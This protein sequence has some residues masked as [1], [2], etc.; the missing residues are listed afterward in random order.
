MYKVK[1]SQEE[2]ERF[3]GIS[4]EGAIAVFVYSKNVFAD[5]EIKHYDDDG[6]LRA[7]AF[8]GEIYVPVSFFERFLGKC[9]GDVGI[10]PRVSDGIEYMPAVRGAVA[11]GYSADVF[12]EGRLCVIGTEDQLSVMRWSENMPEAAA[13]TLFGEYDTS[14]LTSDDY[15]TA[16]ARWA[17]MLVGDAE[18]N[19][20]SDPVIKEKVEKVEKL[21]EDLWQKMNKAEDRIAL[22]GEKP[23]E[24]SATMGYWYTYLSNM[25]KAWGT[26]GTRLYHNEELAADI[27]DGL[28]WM[29]EHYYGEDV[30]NG[31]GWRSPKQFNW[32]DWFIPVPQAITEI[33]FIMEDHF[34][35]E[36]R[37]KYL[38]CFEW[39]TTHTYE[40]DI[41]THAAGRVGVYTMC[42]LATE[43]PDM[44]KRANVDFDWLLELV[45]DQE[46][47][48]VDFS[49]W[50]HGMAYNNAYGVMNLERGLRLAHF[51]AGTPLEFTSPRIYTYFDLVKY[52]F[53]P[54]M[55]N[56]R[57]MHFMSGRQTYLPENTRCVGI[58][59]QMLRIYGMFGKAEDEY[60]RKM[61]LHHTKNNPELVEKMKTAATIHACRQI[62]EL[63]KQ[64]DEDVPY[65]Y[66][67]SYYTADRAVQQRNN[68]AFAIT[69]SS[70]REPAFEATN[71]VN[72]NGWHLGDGMTHIYTDYD[73]NAYSPDNFYLKNDE[74][75]Y[76]LSGTTE[77]A[78]ERV[79]VCVA[80][81]YRAK[82]DFA[83]SVSVD[84][85]Y[86]VAAMEFMSLN[87]PDGPVWENDCG[88]S[89]PI[90]VND[91]T[92]KKSY[93]CFDK[94]MVCLG[95]GIRSTMDSPVSTTVEHVRI[96]SPD[97][98]E[99]YLGGEL[100]P[101]TDFEKRATGADFVNMK[102]HAGFVIFDGEGYVHRYSNEKTGLSYF[103]VGIDHGKNPS[104]ASYA[105]AVLPYADNGTLANYKSCGGV[106]IIK[107]T[108]ECQAVKKASVG[109]SAYVFY[110]AGECDGIKVDAP[111]IVTVKKNDDG[112]TTL[113]ITDPTQ[114]SLKVG[115][116]LSGVDEI[117]SS[118]S[119]IDASVTDGCLTIT[120]NT[121]NARGRRFEITVK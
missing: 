19:D 75:A 114:K 102:G 4:R 26:Y 99:Q 56:G 6:K 121:E 10:P 120:V 38:R 60:L 35:L 111:A 97:F 24:E 113:Q 117:V 108:A 34:T 68:Y 104:D 80:N 49:Q 17:Y 77:D 54:V 98:D 82:N 78:R 87:N 100:L 70:E 67:H 107:N 52:M 11:L 63:L 40:K 27:L 76:R 86:I 94:E 41:R 39:I 20:L 51:L 32:W 15:K 14:K 92:A 53:E 12:Y 28:E 65:E 101:K 66:A 7:V 43:N 109:L 8:D 95:A 88:H 3:L 45:D 50:T 30:I 118:S 116:T 21:G 79:A 44:L 83:G 73:P 31:V 105:Y 57:A 110:E 9:A 25:A 29:Y 119:K 22:F 2:K 89:L 37:R 62:D 85:K 16:R 33:T 61:L 13:Y 23:I 18:V 106:E 103:E 64:D 59:W 90:H 74:Q 115:V 47:P 71:F 84:G 42:A 1:Y 36:S 5:G 46:G 72:L 81:S 96:V 91:L 69:L 55:Y 93:F 112:T 48:R 58:L